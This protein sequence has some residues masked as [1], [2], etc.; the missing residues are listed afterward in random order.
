MAGTFLW[1]VD[2]NVV[3]SYGDDN[4]PTFFTIP[5]DMWE[6]MGKPNSIDILVTAAE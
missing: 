1:Q 6:G 4:T 2:D 5:A 3:F